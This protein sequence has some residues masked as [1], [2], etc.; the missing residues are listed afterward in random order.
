MKLTTKNYRQLLSI[1]GR[2]RDTGGEIR[3]LILVVTNPKAAS[4]KLRYE[5]DGRERWL[6]LG[7]ARLIKLVDARKRALAA[8]IQLL[9]GI[10]P[11]QAKRDARRQAAEAAAK[12]MSFETATREYFIKHSREWRNQKHRD[13]FLSTMEEYAFPKIGKLSVGAIDVSLVLS[14]LEQRHE[15]YP[16]QTLWE[17]IPETASRLRGRIEN[18]LDWAA[19]HGLRSGDNPARWRGFI[20]NALP[21][22]P[23]IKKHFVALPYSELNHFMIELRARESVAARALEFTILTAARTGEVIGATWDEIDLLTGVWTVP[24]ERMKGGKQHRVPFSDRAI[25]ILN[26]LPVEESNRNLFI[27]EG[28]NNQLAKLSMP[29]LLRRMR[30]DDITVHGFR[31]CFMDWAHDTTGYPKVVIDMA[32]AHVVGDKVEAAYRRGDMFDKRR[33]LMDEWAQYCSL[34]IATAKVIRLR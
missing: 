19:V 17:A 13:Q 7:S 18:I 34:P 15:K 23:K 26:A 21:S 27:G 30:S 11:L 2:Y 24:A 12:A 20:E 1:P 22:R 32:L 31:S 28:E 9:N 16:D 4:W 3:G 10:D 8:R 5:I 14:V 6:G 25:E 29:K 33:R